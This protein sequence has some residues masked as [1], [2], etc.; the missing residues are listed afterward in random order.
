VPDKN[1]YSHVH[2]ALQYGAMEVS[3][4][5]IRQSERQMYSA[6]AAYNYGQ[7]GG[8]GVSD[9]TWDMFA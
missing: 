9:P 4:D 7:S 1:K 5:H 2:D 8:L 3:I 6:A